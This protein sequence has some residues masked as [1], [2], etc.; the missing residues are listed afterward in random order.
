[1]LRHCMYVC[2]H[3]LCSSAACLR[4]TTI[5]GACSPQQCLTL[6]EVRPLPWR[7]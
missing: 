7:K 1:M 4:P 2:M 6:L 3:A 5:A